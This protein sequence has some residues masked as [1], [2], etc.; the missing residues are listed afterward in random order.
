MAPST[1]LARTRSNDLAAPDCPT[2]QPPAGFS[3][4][5]GAGLLTVLANIVVGL[6]TGGV[7][8]AVTAAGSSATPVQRAESA[9]R[10]VVIGAGLHGVVLGGI[11]FV[12]ARKYPHFSGATTYVGIT[13]LGLAGLGAIVPSQAFASMEQAT[14]APPSTAATTPPPATTTNPAASLQAMPGGPAMDPLRMM[15]APRFKRTTMDHVMPG[16]AARRRVPCC[17]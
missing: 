6:V 15:G 3:T 7:A 4:S 12:T 17:A 8:A 5:L 10:G 9:K 13:A 2:M 14:S 11:G 1:S 16:G